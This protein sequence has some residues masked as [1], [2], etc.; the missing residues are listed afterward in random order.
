MKGLKKEKMEVG[1][2]RYTYYATIRHILSNQSMD[3]E[4][5]CSSLS[6]SCL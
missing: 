5:E 6:A 3:V 4:R 2:N 1:H